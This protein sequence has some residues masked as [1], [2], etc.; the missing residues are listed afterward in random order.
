LSDVVVADADAVAAA[1]VRRELLFVSKQLAT[2]IGAER[3]VLHDPL[4][5]PAIVSDVARSTR[6]GRAL[7]EESTWQVVL[8]DG[9]GDLAS[10]ME[11]DLRVRMRRLLADGEQAIDGMDPSRGW[12]EFETW[13]RK[14]AAGEAVAH[15]QVL[16]HATE[17]LARI[18]SERF[19]LDYAS[20]DVELPRSGESVRSLSSLQVEFKKS[21][22][23]QALGAMTAARLT[24][25]GVVVSAAVASSAG[26]FLLAPAIGAAVGAGALLT[27]HLVHDETSRQLDLRRAQGKQAFRKYVDEVSF[28]LTK[29]SRDAVRRTQRYL[30]DDFGRRARLV[31]VGSEH[32]LAAVR[33]AAQ[34]SAI[35]RPQ[36]LTEA[37]RKWEQ[38][39]ELATMLE[40]RRD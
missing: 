29:E 23:R 12:P 37:E 5:A 8:Q 1:S 6:R 40:S 20:V 35:E 39:Q 9:L 18:V 16:V 2:H 13:S 27:R 4:A 32:A 21:K 15:M 34:T 30:R 17:S 7:M 38:L 22:V 28:V 10:E 14:A 36:R 25:Y 33:A 24:Y 3:D 19:D 26:T 11:H 31:S